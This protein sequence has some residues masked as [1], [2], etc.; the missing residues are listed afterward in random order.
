MKW[1]SHDYH[2]KPYLIVAG[3]NCWCCVY[4]LVGRKQEADDGLGGGQHQALHQRQAT[5]KVTFEEMENKEDFAIY[6]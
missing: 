4:L 6:I 5:F 2:S 3:V 1:L